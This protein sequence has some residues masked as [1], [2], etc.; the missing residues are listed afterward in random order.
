MATSPEDDWPALAATIPAPNEPVLQRFLA[1]RTALIAEEKRQRADHAFRHAMT[2]IAHRA[3]R[4]VAAIRAA[5]QRTLWT[6][7]FEDA[8]A[9]QPGTDTPTM[10]PGMMFRLAKPRI[11]A[12]RLWRIVRRMPKG[13]ILHAHL[14]AIVD[15]D[16]VFRV[17][18]AEPGM[19]VAAPDGHLA[20]AGARADALV[21]FR[22]FKAERNVAMSIWD[23]EGGYVPGEFVPLVKA[24][25]GFPD[26]GREGWIRWMKSKTTISETDSLEQHR[27]VDHVWKKFNMCF[28]IMGTVL[29]Y[30]PVFRKFLRR[31]MAQYLE[32]GVFW[33]EL[34]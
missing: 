6:P 17:L 27:G 33:G 30:E 1:G 28:Q 34:R 3:H 2:P 23:A 19:H 15:L 32:D 7:Q 20:T 4:I 25:E 10:H 29:H 9:Q 13:S 18:L 16:W 24:A 26:G 22:F 31:L 12:S 21:C 14:D 8:L 11:E 5:E